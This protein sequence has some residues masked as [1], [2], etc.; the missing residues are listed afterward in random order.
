MDSILHQV[1]V[2]VAITLLGWLGAKVHSWRKGK[3]GALNSALL[4]A[5]DTVE[6]LARSSVGA[7]SVS[8]YQLLAKG[9]VAVQLA[10][11]GYDVDR[12][13]LT[14]YMAR[15]AI[16]AGG[17]KLFVALHPNPT[18]LTVPVP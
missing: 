2:P 16:I 13:P 9:A 4:A 18:S 7:K 15:E 12:L 3:R 8:E 10:K 14:L 6:A 1:V 17:T 11:L 5:T